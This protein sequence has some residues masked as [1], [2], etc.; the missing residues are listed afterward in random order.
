MGKY[1]TRIFKS[2]IFAA[3][4]RF[5]YAESYYPGLAEVRRYREKAVA[6]RQ[7]EPAPYRQA[8]YMTPAYPQLYLGNG[9][10]YVVPQGSYNVI[11]K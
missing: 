3:V 8:Y 2:I 7:I 11:L 6:R 9:P 1:V 5:N 4:V 10:I